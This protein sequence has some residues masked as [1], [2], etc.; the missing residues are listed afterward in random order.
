MKINR[1]VHYMQPCN[2]HEKIDWESYYEGFIGSRLMPDGIC[3]FIYHIYKNEDG[4]YSVTADNNA[5]GAERVAVKSR[6]CKNK[7]G[8]KYKESELKAL[9]KDI[10]NGKCLWLYVSHCSIVGKVT[11]KE[12]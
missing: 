2:P 6:N 12:Y 5:Y 4:T 9:M 7:Y 8:S 1:P 11:T 3:N 10:E